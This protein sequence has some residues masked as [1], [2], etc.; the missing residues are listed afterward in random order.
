MLVVALTLALLAPQAQGRAVFLAWNAN[1]KAART[2]SGTL[3]SH[4]GFGSARA[5]F[6]LKKPIYTDIVGPFVEIHSDGK[7]LHLYKPQ[8]KELNSYPVKESTGL[9]GPMLIGLE[10]FGLSEPLVYESEKTTSYNGKRVWAVTVSSGSSALS[11]EKFLKNLY[12]DM[13]TRTL[14]AFEDFG[15]EKLLWGVYEN[16]RLGK[17]MTTKSFA[18]TPPKGA[19]PPKIVDVDDELLRK[20]GTIAPDFSLPALDGTTI[21]LSEFAKYSKATLVWFWTPEL[22]DCRVQLPRL[23]KQF[24]ALRA[25]GLKILAVSMG[26]EASDVEKLWKAEDVGFP[27]LLT[28]DVVIDPLLAYGV[29]TGPIHYLLDSKLKIIDRY[30]GEDP[31]RLKAA[32]K[33]VG[34]T[35]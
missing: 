20:V 34:I 7:M 27:T 35:Y 23:Q 3:T 19:K 8:E 13:K 21:K 18:W 26:D 9:M 10:A 1:L 4:I 32:L 12:F 22:D 24:E 25:K 6:R 17:S 14:V 2:I 5:K 15:G 16:L 33:K 30:S 31:V 11:G 28:S 29:T